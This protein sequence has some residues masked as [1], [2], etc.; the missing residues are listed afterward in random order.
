ML[1]LDSISSPYHDRVVGSIDI[2][3]QFDTLLIRLVSFPIREEDLIDIRVNSPLLSLPSKS[4]SFDK[5]SQTSSAPI[6]L[7]LWA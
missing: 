2:E 7:M 3:T 5:R 4:K 1:Y 6:G